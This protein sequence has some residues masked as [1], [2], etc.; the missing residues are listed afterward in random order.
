MGEYPLR[1]INQRLRDLGAEPLKKGGF[2][3]DSEYLGRRI[4]AIIIGHGRGRKRYTLSEDAIHDLAGK[5]SG[6]AESKYAP[7][8]GDRSYFVKVLK[9]KCKVDKPRH[10]TIED[11]LVFL[12]LLSGLVTFS[13]NITGYSVLVTNGQQSIGVAIVLLFL[14]LLTFILKKANEK[15]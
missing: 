11:T 10:K 5:L 14:G 15:L 9:G 1:K 8:G 7:H 2:D 3:Y 6:I 13:G 12:M 4:P